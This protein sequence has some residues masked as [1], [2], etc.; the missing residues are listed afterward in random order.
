MRGIELNDAA[1]LAYLEDIRARLSAGAADPQ[2]I[3]YET[4]RPPRG[5]DPG[6]APLAI[7]TLEKPAGSISG[8]SLELVFKTPLQGL[9]NADAVWCRWLDGDGAFVMDADCGLTASAALLQF[10][11][12]AIETGTIYVPMPAV[13]TA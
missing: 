12:L 6:G 3:V 5:G 2:V 7:G 11:S 4:S 9:R 8:L 1:R 13:L 10:D